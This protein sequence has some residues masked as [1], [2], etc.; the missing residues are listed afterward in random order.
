MVKGITCDG[1][2][3]GPLGTEPDGML[4]LIPVNPLLD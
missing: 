3:S 1:A 2:I 4:S